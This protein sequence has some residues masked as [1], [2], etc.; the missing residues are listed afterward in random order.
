MLER[1]EPILE[2]KAK[3]RQRA[4]GGD[5][6]NQYTGGKVAVR[7]NLP[8]PA[9]YESGK[10]RNQLAKEL[11]VSKAKAVHFTEPLFRHS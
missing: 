5:R 7:E 8:Q 9:N 11:G 1:K 4:A 6:G 2:I 3:E 10:V